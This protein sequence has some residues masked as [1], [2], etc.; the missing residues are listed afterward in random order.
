MLYDRFET[1]VGEPRG[2]RTQPYLGSQT[3]LLTLRLFTR[4]YDWNYDCFMTVLLILGPVLLI[5]G[6]VLLILGPIL[7]L[8]WTHIDPQMDLPHASLLSRPQ[9]PVSVKK[10]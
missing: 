5:L 4:P 6:P 7:T 8:R 9:T 2:V 3:G 10:T 1:L